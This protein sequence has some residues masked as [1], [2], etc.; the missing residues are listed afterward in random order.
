MQGGIPNKMGKDGMRQALKALC[1][2]VALVAL[3]VT[4]AG[5][6]ENVAGPVLKDAYDLYQAGKLNEASEKFEQGLRMN[7][8]RS[9]AAVGF[10]MLGETYRGMGDSFKAKANYEASL[11]ADPNS[12]VAPQAKERLDSVASAAPPPGSGMQGA[13]PSQNMPPQGMAPQNV[14]PPPGAGMQ[15]AVPP[16]PP[17]A[18][19]LPAPPPP[20]QQQAIRPPPGQPQGGPPPQ[21]QPSAPPQP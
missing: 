12:Q 11:Q 1:W 5:A 16:P 2:A 8:T 21:A 19:R 9:Q 6:Q 17:T 10:F 13:P 15:G 4:A 3:G 18:Q 14:P 7:P 20:R